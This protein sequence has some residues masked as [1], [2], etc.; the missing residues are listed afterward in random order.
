MINN[1][2]ENSFQL[3]LS[4]GSVTT[5]YAN[6]HQ[7]SSFSRHTKDTSKSRGRRSH[8]IIRHVL[9]VNCE[10]SLWSCSF[11]LIARDSISTKLKTKPTPASCCW[12]CVLNW[13]ETMVRCDISTYYQLFYHVEN[14][15]VGKF[16]DNT[17]DTVSAAANYYRIALCIV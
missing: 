9:G 14:F 13:I 8:G 12:R 10:S 3:L 16:R 7:R 2:F 6:F 5:V 11:N 4:L 1:Q 15:S 17:I